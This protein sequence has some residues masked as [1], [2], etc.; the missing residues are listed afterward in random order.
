MA[1]NRGTASAGRDADGEGAGAWCT[2]GR[3]GE[4]EVD[5]LGVTTDTLAVA[6]A[7]RNQVPLAFEERLSLL[8]LA[9]YLQLPPPS[10]ERLARRGALPCRR[11]SGGLRFNRREVDCTLDYGLAGCRNAD[12]RRLARSGGRGARLTAALDAVNVF[13]GVHTGGSPSCLEQLINAANLPDDVDR[14]AL[15][16]ALVT[17]ERLSSTVVRKSAIVHSSR[18]GR[19]WVTRNIV[20]IATTAEYGPVISDSGLSAGVV[21]V[22]LAADQVSHARLLARA[23]SVVRLP[24]F[25]ETVRTA[26]TPARICDIVRQA[27]QC[28]FN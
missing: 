6:D 12:V 21:I 28:L 26:A 27:E 17:R 9:A 13:Q 14:R 7:S 5:E 16:A 11:T 8:A 1:A 18:A 20:A 19:R 24:G 3:G 10:V 4:C 22:V 2:E 23:I 25:V 15:L